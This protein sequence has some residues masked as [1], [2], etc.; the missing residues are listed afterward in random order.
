[1]QQPAT[2]LSLFMETSCDRLRMVRER[3]NQANLCLLARQGVCD[4]AI[5]G[6]AV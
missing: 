1:M 3:E 6:I 5:G 2:N 4:T